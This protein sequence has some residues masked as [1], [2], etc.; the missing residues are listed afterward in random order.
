MSRKKWF[1]VSHGL[2]VGNISNP[3]RSWGKHHE[4]AALSPWPFVANGSV[5]QLSVVIRS[6]CCLSVSA[7]PY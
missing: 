3:A 2:L 5:C 7:A 1:L 6:L 4:V